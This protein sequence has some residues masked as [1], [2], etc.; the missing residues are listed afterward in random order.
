MLGLRMMVCGNETEINLVKDYLK[1]AGRKYVISDK[2]D[3]SELMYSGLEFITV[4]YYEGDG[5]DQA[6]LV[7][8]TAGTSLYDA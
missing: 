6:K 8:L 5:L 2:T 3:V 4:I 7:D 1:G